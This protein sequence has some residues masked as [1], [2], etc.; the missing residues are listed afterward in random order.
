MLSFQDQYTLA[1]NMSQ[2]NSAAS[3]VFFKQ[4][5]NIGQ[6]MLEAAIDS[7]YTEETI[8]RSTSVNIYAYKCP[9]DIVRVVEA[10]QMTGT[11]QY[12]LI[13][14]YNEDEWQNIRSLTRNSAND[15]PR[16]IFVRK[17]I[18]EL[19]T[20]SAT[21]SNTIYLRYQATSGLLQYA[22]YNAGTITTLA[23]L[24]TGATGNSTTFT[25]AMIGRYFKVDS[26][27]NWYKISDVASATALTIDA[28]YQGLAISAG[29]ESYTIGQMPRTPES[30]H[31][32]PVWYSLM[33][34]YLG[35]KQNS[36][37]A[38]LYKTMYD[39]DFAL[40]KKLY[41]KRVGSNYIPGRKRYRETANPNNFPTITS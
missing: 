9:V 41:G 6:G 13:P 3:L 12:N 25:N 37:S 29:S 4:G 34:Y 19:D 15:S 40:A 2:D 36:D 24:G 35:F 31:T 1:Q 28:P 22:D 20:A 10:Y 27:G 16:Y 26:E 30:T 38:V 18:F 21:A 33:M 17:G 11:T 23:A 8:T 7:Y 5:I 14:I 39:S 32:I